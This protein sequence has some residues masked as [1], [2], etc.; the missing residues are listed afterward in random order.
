MY[1]SRHC[2]INSKIVISKH[3][4]NIAQLAEK[5]SK[6]SKTL[7]SN[8]FP[9]LEFFSIQVNTILSYFCMIA[10]LRSIIFL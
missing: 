10:S 1:T 9:I 5:N 6:K 3:S 8:Y 2:S 7:I 4:H